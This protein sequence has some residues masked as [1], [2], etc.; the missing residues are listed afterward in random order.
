MAKYTQ[1]ELASKLGKTRGWLN[2]YTK[3]GGVTNPIVKDGLIDDSIPQNRLFIDKWLAMRGDVP[4]V[5]TEPKRVKE[6]PKQ[7]NEEE[8]VSLAE[9]KLKAEIA[10]KLG[11]VEKLKLEQAKLRGSSI[12]I[13]AVGALITSLGNGFQQSYKSGADSLMMELSNKYKIPAKG[14]AELKGFLYSLINDSHD[15]GVKLSKKD[16]RNIISDVKFKDEE[17]I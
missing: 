8:T 13:D 9:Q 15:R 10:Y 14:V 1:S 5:K 12:P 17:S 2:V 4:K 3:R 6:E 11:Q 7:V 16:L